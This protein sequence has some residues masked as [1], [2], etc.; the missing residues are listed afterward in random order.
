MLSARTGACK[1]RG[2]CIKKVL[3]FCPGEEHDM[4]AIF[5][6]KEKGIQYH[7]VFALFLTLILL[8]ANLANTK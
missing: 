3:S 7:T 2:N 8:V 4:D 6:P 1:T 5:I